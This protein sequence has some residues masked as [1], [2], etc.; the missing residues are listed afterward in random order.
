MTPT[1]I[2]LPEPDAGSGATTPPI[3]SMI[4]QGS[5]GKLLE[6]MAA[7]RPNTELLTLEAGHVTHHDDLAG[8]VSGVRGLLGKLR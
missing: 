8:F 2:P 3:G 6:S 7:R 1:I 5:D 4:E